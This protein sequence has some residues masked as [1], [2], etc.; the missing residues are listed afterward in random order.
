MRI[1]V[2]TIGKV[3]LIKNTCNRNSFQVPFYIY[4]HHISFTYFYAI[5]KI[6]LCSWI[7]LL[8]LGQHLFVLMI[9]LWTNE[10]Y[11]AVTTFR[12]KLKSHI[13]L[14]QAGSCS[15]LDPHI[16]LCSSRFTDI[17]IKKLQFICKLSFIYK[18]SLIIL[19][20]YIY[21]MLLL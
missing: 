13:Y 3:I 18:L 8:P 19:V 21:L 2:Q 16:L 1:R 4:V 7:H 11:L 17:N 12:M 5:L 14:F 10:W 20:Y 15:L 9:G 6:S